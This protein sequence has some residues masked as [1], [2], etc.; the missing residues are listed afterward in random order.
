LKSQHKI[1]QSTKKKYIEDLN[2]HLNELEKILNCPDLCIYEHF[3]DLINEVDLAF[4]TKKYENDYGDFKIDEF[5]N[6]WDETIAKINEFKKA[7][8]IEYFTVETKILA[9]E[10]LE[11]LRTRV[12][13]DL[14]EN[15]YQEMKSIISRETNRLQAI[16]FLNK[17]ILFIDKSKCED[18]RLLRQNDFKLIE[19]SDEF[20]SKTGVQLLKKKYF[21]LL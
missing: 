15:S 13:E 2:E 19:I 14:N 11:S 3:S 1:M 6:K 8:S 17:T 16:L 18:Q 10:L 20:I 4:E 9:S 21:I 12:N 7:N 5:N